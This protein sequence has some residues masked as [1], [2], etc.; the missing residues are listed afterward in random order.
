[1]TFPIVPASQV[2][3]DSPVGSGPYVITQFI[4]GD[5]MTL[6]ANPNWWTTQ[7]YVRQIMVSFH[8]TARSVIDSYEYNRVD[9]VFTRSIAAAQYKTGTLSV[10]MSYRTNQ[11]ECLYMNNSAFEL[12]PEVRK[13]IRLVIDK[14]KIISN[15]YSGMAVETNF[16]F[17]PAAVDE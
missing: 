14:Q 11:L 1:M 6:E 16:P 9:A 2:Y 15:I 12:T 7:P 17:F 3:A 10:S 8:E 13:A 4:A 5:F